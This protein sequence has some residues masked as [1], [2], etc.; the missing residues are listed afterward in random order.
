MG[1]IVQSVVAST[2]TQAR[3]KGISLVASI[4]DGLPVGFGDE[5]RLT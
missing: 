4:A 2:E 3:T 5:R 1:Q